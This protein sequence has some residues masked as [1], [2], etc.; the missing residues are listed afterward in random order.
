MSVFW[1]AT[2]TRKPQDSPR[3]EINDKDRWDEIKSRGDNGYFTMK[4]LSEE[5]PTTLS[6][7]GQGL[8]DTFTGHGALAGNLYRRL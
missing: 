8:S 7:S 6:G 4:G 2:K 1:E 3:L 5:M